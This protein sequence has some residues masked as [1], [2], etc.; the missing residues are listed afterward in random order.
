MLDRCSGCLQPRLGRTGSAAEPSSDEIASGSRL[1]V[2]AGKT[3]ELRALNGEASFLQAEDER[4]LVE[5]VADVPADVKVV[6]L[7]APDGVTIST[8]Y[9][10]SDPKKTTECLPGQRLRC[11]QLRRHQSRSYEQ[12]ADPWGNHSGGCG[13]EKESWGHRSCGHGHHVGV[14]VRPAYHAG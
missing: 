5:Y 10:S 12:E 7:T 14:R 9:P 3:F 13:K 2:A 8:V 4:V 1:P 11:R 6:A